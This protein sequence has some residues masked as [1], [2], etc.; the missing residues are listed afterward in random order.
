MPFSAAADRHLR[1]LVIAKVT[2]TLNAINFN[3]DFLCAEGLA[4]RLKISL[5]GGA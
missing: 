4:F 3:L 5:D 1:A 2:S